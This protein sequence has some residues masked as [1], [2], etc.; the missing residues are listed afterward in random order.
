M[1]R[2]RFLTAV[3]LL[4]TLL[5]TGG[6]S[7]EEAVQQGAPLPEGKYPLELTATLA[8]QS[9]TTRATTANTWAGGETVYLYEG[10]ADKAGTRHEYT[11]DASGKLTPK[12]EQNTIWWNSTGETKHLRAVYSSRSGQAATLP[13]TEQVSLFPGQNADGYQGSDFLYAPLTTVSFG[14]KSASLTFNHQ[15]AKIVVHVRGEGDF[16]KNATFDTSGNSD[17]LLLPNAYTYGKWTMPA[18]DGEQ[19]TWSGQGS[20]ATNYYRPRYLGENKK[21][22]IDGKEETAVRSYEALVVPRAYEK[23][24]QV[25]R[26]LFMDNNGKWLNLYYKAPEGGITWEGGKQYTYAVTAKNGI[27]TVSVSTPAQW[28]GSEETVNGT[29]K[30]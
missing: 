28:T 8:G 3:V 16:I 4:A 2:N 23:D 25:F 14:S 11:V 22:T 12:D 10:T 18:A 5:T 24:A 9:A 17:G 15:V 1:E 20:G 13:E 19:G 6:C 26:L 29:E 7:Q 30:E 27:L 21:F